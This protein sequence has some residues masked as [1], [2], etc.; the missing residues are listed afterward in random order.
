LELHHD[1]DA[2][3]ATALVILLVGTR[4]SFAPYQVRR[5]IQDNYGLAGVDFTLHRY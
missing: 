4:P 1:E 3:V 2:L 5:H